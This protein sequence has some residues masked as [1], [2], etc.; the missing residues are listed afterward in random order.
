MTLPRNTIVASELDPSARRSGMPAW[1]WAALGAVAIA[2]IYFVFGRSGSSGSDAE[3]SLP[4]PAAVAVAPAE[5]ERAFGGDR[6][7]RCKRSAPFRIGR[8]RAALTARSG[9]RRS[10]MPERA[11]R[12]GPEKETDRAAKVP[13]ATIPAPKPPVVAPE[14]GAIAKSRPAKIAPK[15]RRGEGNPA[16]SDRSSYLGRHRCR[17]REAVSRAVPDDH[18]RA[19]HA[20][21]DRH[22]RHDAGRAVT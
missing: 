5:I 12:S 18:D 16:G 9:E 4:K 6:P 19:G 20:D 21:S 17:C 1:I 8:C 14:S 13:V 22:G 3:A 15:H 2:T 11:R 10:P 7:A